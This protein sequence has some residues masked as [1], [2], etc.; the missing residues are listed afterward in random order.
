MIQIQAQPELI[1]HRRYWE[2]EDTA[3]NSLTALLKADSIKAYGSE[4]DIW[5]ISDGE[6]VVNRDAHV[7]LNDHKLIVQDTPASILT[8]EKLENGDSLPTI[9]RYLDTFEKCENTKTV[10]KVEHI[11]RM[12][13]LKIDYITTYETSFSEKMSTKQ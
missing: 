8:Q 13:D 6:L 2:I 12:I 5:L 9:E 10:N 1:A 3:Q 4:L 11:Q 7:T